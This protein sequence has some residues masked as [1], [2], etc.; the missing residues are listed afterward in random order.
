[1]N[2][3]PPHPTAARSA[4]TN[5]NICRRL[6]K[7]G[8]PGQRSPRAIPTAGES[9]GPVCLVSPP[10]RAS[11]SVSGRSCLNAR[12]QRLVGLYRASRCSDCHADRCAWRY[13]CY[14][15]LP[16]AL[17]Y[18]DAGLIRRF[19]GNSPSPCRRPPIGD[20]RLS[21]HL[22]LDRRPPRCLVPASGGSD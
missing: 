16:S 22:V 10:P 21:S 14:R 2:W 18:D 7:P 20:A 6:A 12:W 1:M 9:I 17:L 4:T 13:R 15:D 5:G 19:R 8:L 3:L 11:R